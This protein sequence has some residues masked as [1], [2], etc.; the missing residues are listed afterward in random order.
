MLL[1]TLSILIYDLDSCICLIS[2]VVCRNN[3]GVG[4]IA[5]S[6]L[7]YKSLELCVSRS[8]RSASHAAD[9]GE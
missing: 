9:V 1:A 6:A 7:D 2:L 8:I 5:L 3:G 4:H